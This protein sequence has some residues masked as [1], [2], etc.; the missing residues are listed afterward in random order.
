LIKG[1]A[2]VSFSAFLWLNKRP[3][4]REVFDVGTGVVVWSFENE[5]SMLELGVPGDA[6]QGVGADM[7]FTDVPV[8]VDARVVGGARVVE[9]NGADVFEFDGLLNSLKQPFETVF[10]ANVVTRRESVCG[11]ETNAQRKFRTDAHDL[12]EV[13]DAVTDAIAL[14]GRVLEQNAK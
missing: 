4:H 2:F 7:A 13:L 10:F 8:A 9:V 6:L 1:L 3:Q 14:A 11:V 5:G 12:V